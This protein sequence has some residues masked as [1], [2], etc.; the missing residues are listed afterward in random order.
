[1]WEAVLVLAILSSDYLLNS[2][3]NNNPFLDRDCSMLV[4]SWPFFKATFAIYTKLWIG[5]QN[6]ATMFFYTAAGIS[7]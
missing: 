2:K 6:A 3:S 7:A 4:L 5:Q 1:M